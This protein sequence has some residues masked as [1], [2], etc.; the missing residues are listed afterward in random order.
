MEIEIRDDM[1]RLGQ[2]LKLAGLV[3]DGA[4][5]KELLADEA[6]RVNGEIEIRRGRQVTKG[7]VVDVDLPQGAERITV[8]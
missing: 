3:E 7:S 4:D 5:A 8:I 2:L 6:V 1:I